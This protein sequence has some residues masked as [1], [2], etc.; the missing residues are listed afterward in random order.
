MKE[1][2]SEVPLWQALEASTRS[3]QLLTNT[4]WMLRIGTEKKPRWGEVSSPLL[5]AVYTILG[6]SHSL[7]HHRE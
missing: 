2:I 3:A 5:L 1:K 4:G 7:A 6:L